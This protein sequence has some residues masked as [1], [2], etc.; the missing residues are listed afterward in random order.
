MWRQSMSALDGYRVLVRAYILSNGRVNGTQVKPAPPGFSLCG[1]LIRV[2]GSPMMPS[3]D[4]EQATHAGTKVPDI[5]STQSGTV[6]TS[7]VGC[8]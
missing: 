2:V 8:P 6:E 5:Q 1:T 7:V 3:H 4:R